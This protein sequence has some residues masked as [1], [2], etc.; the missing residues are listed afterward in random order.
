MKAPIALLALA[1][2]TAGLSCGDTPPPG[3][4]TNAEPS[5]PTQPL[6]GSGTPAAPAGP[7]IAHNTPRAEADVPPVG[8]R[9][10][11]FCDAIQ[12]PNHVLRAAQRKAQLIQL[13]G[14]NG[15]HIIHADDQST[16]YYG[17]YRSVSLDDVKPDPRD[18][19][20]AQADLRRI[21]NLTD[22]SGEKIFRATMFLPISE[23]DPEAPP[24]WNLANAP[25][26]AFWSLQIGAYRGNPQPGQPTRKQAAVD[27]V[28]ELRAAGFEGY[29]FHG[30]TVSS[31]CVGAWPRSAVK[32]QQSVGGLAPRDME[33]RSMI[34]GGQLPKNINTENLRDKDGHHVVVQAAKLEVLDPS[35]A[36]AIRKFPYHAIDGAVFGTPTKT[37]EMI[38]DS[39]FLVYVPH[40]KSTQESVAGNGQQR[41]DRSSAVDPASDAI[42]NLPQEPA[43][44][45][46][47]G[48]G[49][50]PSLDDRR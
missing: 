2:A 1:L 32:E 11:L 49:Q 38:P 12:G 5:A 46:V 23:A 15:W 40:A 29:Y 43:P 19:A 34:I 27:S 36:E 30:E 13:T 6:S 3:Q 37:G 42:L 22:S 25:V 33:T 41:I 31:V 4:H 16:I 7:V 35:M 17:Y 47:P 24:Q 10:Q 50:L 8:A 21:G 26:D 28:R 9:F 48:R 44:R 39:S 18:V 45:P 14:D 20:R